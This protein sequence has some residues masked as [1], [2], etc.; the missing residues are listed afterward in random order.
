[1]SLP[2]LHE[3][4]LSLAG[5]FYLW[6]PLARQGRGGSHDHPRG[7]GAVGDRADLVGLHISR[8]SWGTMELSRRSNMEPC[9]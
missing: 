4:D 1:M 9:V 2:V 5:N 8:R 3:S 6:A 7:D